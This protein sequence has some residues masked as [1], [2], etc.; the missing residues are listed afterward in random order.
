MPALQAAGGVS[1]SAKPTIHPAV[2]PQPPRRS[3]ESRLKQK[4]W[5]YPDRSIGL[6]LGRKLLD[7][8]EVVT[9]NAVTARGFR[10]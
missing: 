10:T 9:I 6:R 8:G 2:P 1:V 4:R 3:S 7:V 5:A